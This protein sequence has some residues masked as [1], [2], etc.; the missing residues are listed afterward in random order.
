[1]PDRCVAVTPDII[2]EIARDFRLNV[3][4]EPLVE[5][6]KEKERDREDMDMRQAARTL[7][8]MCSYLQ[9]PPSHE[10]E[11][12]TPLTTRVGKHEPYI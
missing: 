4:H 6:I 1:M 12:R 11:L 3:V 9:K 2:D 10:T 8:D 7:L 5:R